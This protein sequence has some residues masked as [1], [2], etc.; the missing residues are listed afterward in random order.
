MRILERSHARSES[1]PSSDGTSAG[2]DCVTQK[3]GVET[4]LDPGCDPKY[5]VG[6]GLSPQDGS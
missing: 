6:S 5:G 2:K 1:P 3:P 4:E